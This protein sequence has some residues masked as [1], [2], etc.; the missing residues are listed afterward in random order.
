[1]SPRKRIAANMAAS[2]M[3]TIFHLC[4][5][6]AGCFSSVDPEGAALVVG[7]GV[8]VWSWPSLDSGMPLL[9]MLGIVDPG[10]A[11]VVLEGEFAEMLNWVLSV[12]RTVE[13]QRVAE[14][15]EVVV[16]GVEGVAEMGAENEEQSEASQDVSLVWYAWQ[17]ACAICELGCARKVRVVLTVLELLM[18]D[19]YNWRETS[20]WPNLAAWMFCPVDSANQKIV[21]M[22]SR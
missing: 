11:S 22:A 3:A 9:E 19:P 12:D 16:T 14:I 2:A 8:G 18:E 1:M 21:T 15:T 6:L 10:T 13:M 5:T 20:P 4:D 7:I 17:G